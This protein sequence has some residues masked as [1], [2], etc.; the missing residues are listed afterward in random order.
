ML[1]TATARAMEPVLGAGSAGDRLRGALPALL[2][3]TVA[4][5]VARTA[6]AV[7]SYAGRRITPRLTTEM[8]SALVEAVCRVEAAA[9]AEDGFSDRREAAEMGCRVP[10]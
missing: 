2:V 4:A 3:V 10:M 6:R 7:A 5:A 8:D 9:Y 1:L